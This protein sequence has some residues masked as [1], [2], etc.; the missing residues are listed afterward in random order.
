[1]GHAVPNAGLRFSSNWT[2]G[3]PIKGD[4]KLSEWNVIFAFDRAGF[5]LRYCNTGLEHT[6]VSQVRR[7]FIKGI[8][9]I[10]ASHILSI[11]D[12]SLRNLI[13]CVWRDGEACLASPLQS[14]NDQDALGL[15]PGKQL[16][17]LLCFALCL[18]SV[19]LASEPMGFIF[20]LKKAIFRTR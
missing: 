10:G 19:S 4:L 14:F 20:F 11:M 17:H 6:N 5:T 12:S 2:S 7:V 9:R 13:G 15:T 3:A 8:K 1:M 18:I 16:G